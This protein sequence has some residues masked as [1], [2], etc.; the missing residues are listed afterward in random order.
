M[1]V[2]IESCG[3]FNK[4]KSEA[5]RRFCFSAALGGCLVTD[6]TSN[7]M[8]NFQWA[9]ELL[10][11]IL[12]AAARCSAWGSHLSCFLTEQMTLLG[13]VGCI[14]SILYGSCRANL[15]CLPSPPCCSMDWELPQDFLTWEP[16]LVS[17]G[18]QY[19]LLALGCLNSSS[20]INYTFMLYF[21]KVTHSPDLHRK[22]GIA[23]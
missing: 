3:F 22:T 18:V 11:E 15:V 10:K 7:G 23:S 14:F 20:W 13:A 2:S 17:L 8:P 12:A 19:A 6:H 21:L 9:A 16:P 4:K 5:Y 1:R